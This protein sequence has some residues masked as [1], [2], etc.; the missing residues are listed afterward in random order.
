[1]NEVVSKTANVDVIE[2]EDGETC[3][4][5]YEYKIGGDDGMPPAYV[6]ARR[7]GRRQYEAAVRKSMGMSSK[8]FLRR[9]DAGEWHE[10]YDKP[11][12]LYLVRLLMMRSPAEPDTDGSG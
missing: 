9:W 11:G 8:E 6:I 5:E 12:H 1:M 7:E 3:E 10:L 2:L 4:I